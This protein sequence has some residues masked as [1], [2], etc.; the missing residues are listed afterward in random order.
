MI[1][2]PSLAGSSCM[3]LVYSCISTVNFCLWDSTEDSIEDDL[4]IVDK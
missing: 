3:E 4:P 1:K 2:G